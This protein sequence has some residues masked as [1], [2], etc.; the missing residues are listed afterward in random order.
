MKNFFTKR[1]NK[2]LI[3]IEFNEKALWVIEN[4]DREK[5]QRK[6]IIMNKRLNMEMQLVEIKR[7]KKKKKNKDFELI[8]R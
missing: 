5:K 4:F 6:L 7:W 8:K 1:L 3:N 2:K